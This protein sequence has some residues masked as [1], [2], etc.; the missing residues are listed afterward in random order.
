MKAFFCQGPNTVLVKKE[1]E[2]IKEIGH[3][4]LDFCNIN[5]VLRISLANRTKSQLQGLMCEPGI[6]VRR[7]PEGICPM[8][9][10]EAVVDC[11]AFKR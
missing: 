4:D 6:D 11:K 9:M 2:Q 8:I 1:I 5:G 7:Y 10:G 3:I